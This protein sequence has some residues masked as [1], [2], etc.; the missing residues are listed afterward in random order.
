MFVIFIGPHICWRFTVNIF[1][2]T[3]TAVD[4]STIS[5]M[6]PPLPP[7]YPKDNNEMS[8]QKPYVKEYL[9]RHQCI[10]DNSKSR[11]AKA[12]IHKILFMLDLSSCKQWRH[13]ILNLHVGNSR[14][15]RSISFEFKKQDSFLFIYIFCC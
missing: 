7:L 11:I 13:L 5:Q 15:L 9:N 4:V 3:H 14:H 2:T 6:F 8:F 10:C 1:F 12:V